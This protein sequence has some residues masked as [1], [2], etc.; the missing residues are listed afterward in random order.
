MRPALS[1]ENYMTSV[2]IVIAP[3]QPIAEAARLMRLHGVR[4]LP[5]V[6]EGRV[7]G[8]LS[9][10]DV[11][12]IETLRD[13]DPR[14]VRVEEAMTTDVYAV[15]PE[16]SVVSVARH[17]ADKRIGSAVVEHNGKL[18]GLFTTT[19]SLRALAALV[20]ASQVEEPQAASRGTP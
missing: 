5:V 7:I 18:L 2:L 13:V 20:F 6:R 16:E 12:L 11:Y 8:L 9:Q 4:H 15:D 14:R 3:E 17:M 19:D 1:I 10:R